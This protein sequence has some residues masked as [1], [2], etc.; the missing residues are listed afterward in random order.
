MDRWKGRISTPIQKQSYRFLTL[1]SIRLHEGNCY[2]QILSFLINILPEK[3][4]FNYLLNIRGR[5]GFFVRFEAKFHEPMKK[6]NALF[7]FPIVLFFSCG[8]S[9]DSAIL[10]QAQQLIFLIP[11]YL[12]RD[13]GETFVF[14][15][16]DL[17]VSKTSRTLTTSY[18]FDQIKMAYPFINPG[19]FSFRKT[20]PLEIERP[21]GIG[22]DRVYNIFTTKSDKT[23]PAD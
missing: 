19:R 22:T 2:L 7:N 6:L 12:P 1:I 10:S 13:S 11:R 20:L 18:N 5:T 15:T 14:L 21:N 4:W 23:S 16:W 3:G 17:D 9:S 8:E